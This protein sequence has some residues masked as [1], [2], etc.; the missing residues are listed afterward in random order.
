M[1]DWLVLRMSTRY[2]LSV[3]TW[4]E[5]HEGFDTNYGKFGRNLETSGKF[6]N[7]GE[8][9]RKPVNGNLRYALKS[10]IFLKSFASKYF[11]LISRPRNTFF[12]VSSKFHQRLTPLNFKCSEYICET[13]S[14]NW[15]CTV[16]LVFIISLDG[17]IKKYSRNLELLG[18]I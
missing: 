17:K 13:A 3:P 12:S 7:I 6:R 11:S 15:Y 16:F 4:H 8:I 14:D 5:L 9:Y 2:L 1:F 10:S 18:E